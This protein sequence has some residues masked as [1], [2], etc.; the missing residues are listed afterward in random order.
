[1]SN[2]VLCDVLGVT[3]DL[4]IE[5]PGRARILAYGAVAFDDKNDR[6][7][8]ALHSAANSRARRFELARALG[9]AAWIGNTPFVPDSFA[10][11]STAKSDRQK[12]QRAFAQSYLCPFSDVMSALGSEE[13]S[14]SDIERVAGEFDVS[15]R[16]IEMI[17]VNKKIVPRE[18]F[19][20]RLEAA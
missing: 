20:D 7:H 15:Q 1:M 18:R 10:P 6:S 3:E 14:E 11:L 2:A 12:F 8:F 19:A 13:P 5:A 9:D 4:A 17:L 16:V